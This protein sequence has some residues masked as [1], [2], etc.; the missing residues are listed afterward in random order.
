MPTP[1]GH[2]TWWQRRIAQE[3]RQQNECLTFRALSRAKGSREQT[4]TAPTH[5]QVT[6]TLDFAST[7]RREI[8]ERTRNDKVLHEDH[9]NPAAI[10]RRAAEL[11]RHRSPSAH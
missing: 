7:P 1:S 5:T 3:K 4:D 10:Q 9:L 8:P 11:Y 6:T 2:S